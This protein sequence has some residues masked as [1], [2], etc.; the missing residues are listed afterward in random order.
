MNQFLKEI[1]SQPSAL[2]ETFDS[3]RKDSELFSK[4][5]KIFKETDISRIIFT[6]MG[7]SFFSS[8]VPYYFLN[9]NGLNTE[10][11]EAGE[12]LLYSLPRVEQPELEKTVVVLI[13]QSGESGEVVK[14]LE[15]FKAMVRPSITIG[16]TNSPNS[17]LAL[18]SDI[19]LI[20]RAGVE[21]SVTSK[22]YVST[23]IVLY[24]LSKY[25]ILKDLSGINFLAVQQ[26][27]D[28]VKD[29]L[30]N[31]E[32]NDIFYNNLLSFFG[33]ID[34]LEILARGPSLS[35][36]YQAALNFKE[37]CKKSSEA[38]SLS[39]F[40]HG[41]IECLNENSKLILISS[42]KT[43]FELNVG[44]IKKL[45]QDWNVGKILHITNIDFDPNDEILNSSPK[46]ISFKHDI[47][48][49]FLAPIME[50]IILQLFFYKIAEKNN[51]IPGEFRFTQKITKEI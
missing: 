31:T 16:I 47:H 9:Q 13:S 30:N 45:L 34:H 1:L 6:G 35:T 3:L 12:F 49:P 36:A 28:Q 19:P 48:N 15:Q 23:L 42:D 32:K 20:M 33:D 25:F 11:R 14:L 22:S 24:C 2:S 10:M 51:I 38:S 40:R 27:I 4:I 46:L 5:V 18:K 8:Y 44:F 41:G 7:S 29:F 26:V 21:E 17:T 43:N 39:T 37:I 50:I